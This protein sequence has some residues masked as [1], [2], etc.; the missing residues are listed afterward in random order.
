MERLHD[1]P[2]QDFVA[3]ETHRLI[4]GFDQD[5]TGSLTISPKC[6]HTSDCCQIDVSARLRSAHAMFNDHFTVE[7]ITTFTVPRTSTNLATNLAAGEVLI[8]YV[9]I[10]QAVAHGL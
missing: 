3:H 8:V 2:F 9:C 4:P 1:R 7:S 5:A 10:G 6:M